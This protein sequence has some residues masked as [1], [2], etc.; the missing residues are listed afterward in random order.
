MKSILG[1]ANLPTFA[2]FIRD[3]LDSGSDKDNII[4]TITVRRLETLMHLAAIPHGF[5][6]NLNTDS[7]LQLAEQLHSFGISI[8][9]ILDAGGHPEDAIVS[10]GPEVEMSPEFAREG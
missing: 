3:E 8:E 9:L 4:G 10:M 5:Y 2:A 1:I 6:S 7:W